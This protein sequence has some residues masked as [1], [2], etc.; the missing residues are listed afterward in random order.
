MHLIVLI[1]GDL[2]RINLLI[3]NPELTYNLPIFLAINVSRVTMIRAY[4]RLSKNYPLVHMFNILLV[5]SIL[6]L[7]TYQLLQNNKI[8]YAFGYIVA[9]FPIFIFAKASTYKS[10]Y[11]GDR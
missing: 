2:T 5:F 10:K 8:E 6:I 11:L 3:F 1:F 4:A 9:L 7:C